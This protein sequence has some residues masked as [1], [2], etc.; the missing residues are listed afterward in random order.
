MGTGILAM[1]F[2]AM[3]GW[4]IAGSLSWNAYGLALA[5]ALGLALARSPS[6][7]PTGR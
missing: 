7:A 5:L 2:V 6:T 3:K 4:H 1:H